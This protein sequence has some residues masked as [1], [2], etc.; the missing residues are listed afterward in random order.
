MRGPLY[1]LY[2]IDVL[3]IS[4]TEIAN[5]ANFASLMS[6]AGYLFWGR[7]I[8]RYGA[9]RTVLGGIMLVALIPAVYIGA[10]TV[11]FLFFAAAI[12]GFGFACIDIAYIQSILHYAAPGKAAQ[13]QS[14]HALLLG[15]RG[16]IAPLVG[17]PLMRAYGY[18]PVF[19]GALAL[20]VVGG[21]MQWAA[22][23]RP[24]EAGSLA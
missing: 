6:I 3:K 21:F 1:A 5:L 9:P 23:R 8:D 22:T 11:P 24:E 10:H 7:F 20:M 2:Q 14:L 17:V 19:A 4:N 13:Y 15:L 12:S 16:V 18:R